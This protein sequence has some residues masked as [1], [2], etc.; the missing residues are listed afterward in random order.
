MANLRWESQSPRASKP[1]FCL[2]LRALD[3]RRVM[4]YHTKAEPG[5][6]NGRRGGLKN[7]W[8]QGREGSSPSLGTDSLMNCLKHMLGAVFFRLHGL[9]IARCKRCFSVATTTERTIDH[10]IIYAI[11]RGIGL[12]GVVHEAAPEIR[13]VIFFQC[14]FKN[15][16]LVS[17]RSQRG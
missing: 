3:F 11:K 6:R 8:L 16:S 2:T 1:A 7:R 17:H 13:R 4:R 15:V 14:S 10:M 9:L 5:W 12:S